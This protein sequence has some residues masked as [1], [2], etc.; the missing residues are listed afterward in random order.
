MN[1]R[2]VAWLTIPAAL[3]SVSC[4]DAVPPPG[5]GA[6]GITVQNSSS[7][8]SG[9]ACGSPHMLV[10]GNEAPTPTS[11]GRTW[12]DGQNGKKV[13]CSVKGGGSYEFSG[14][15]SGNDSSFSIRGTAQEGGTG[16]AS[17]Y[18]FDSNMAFGL[19]DE[20]CTVTVTGD[21]KVEKGAIWA[22][23]SCDHMISSDDM[24]LWCAAR[25]TFVF[26]TCED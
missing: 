5:E 19:G 22:D 24:Y 3:L 15:L 21:Y 20:A 14:T 11:Q 18:F 26:K 16:P 2:S 25:G 6:V 12:V 8:P 13:T 1:S 4:G 7:A 23:V 17:V 10:W 9:Y